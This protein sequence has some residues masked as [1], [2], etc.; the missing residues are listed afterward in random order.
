MSK[1]YRIA[2]VARRGR[3]G[4]I[5]ICAVGAISSAVAQAD[6][7]APRQ[8]PPDDPCDHLIAFF[9]ARGVPAAAAPLTLAQ[10]RIYREEKKEL[11]CLQALI[12]LDQ[13]GVAG[14]YLPPQLP[15]DIKGKEVVDSGGA[16]L[17]K[18]ER[19]V[20]SGRSNT[21]YLIVAHGGVF[22]FGA[23][24]TAVAASR[25]VS[26]DGRIMLDVSAEAFRSMPLWKEDRTSFREITLR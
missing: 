3:L 20:V 4:F 5:L 21:P 14:I 13:A 25:A 15:L 24:R 26:A 18:I 12:N 11:S 22:G 2:R 1:A 8:Y 19:A 23:S 10:A 9:E 6:R 7:S 17:G 16:S